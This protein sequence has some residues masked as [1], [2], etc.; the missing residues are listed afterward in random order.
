[1]RHASLLVAALLAGCA[2]SPSSHATAPGAAS[3]DAPTLVLG[4]FD[5]RALA[6]AYFRSEAHA[7]QPSEL[8]AARAQAA[9]DT[10]TMQRLDAEMRARQALAHRQG[11]GGAPIPELLAMIEDEIPAIARRAGVDAVVSQADLLWLDPDAETVD[12]SL[13]LAEAFAPSEE[14]RRM[15]PEV[16]KQK[17]VPLDRIED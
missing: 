1:M 7:T 6:I 16:L 12:L 17:P 9:G 10:T 4:T 11:F 14:T 13:A 8:V 15:L 5:S 2:Q 3:P